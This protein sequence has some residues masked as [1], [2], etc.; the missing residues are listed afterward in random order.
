MDTLVHDRI[1]VVLFSI[2]HVGDIAGSLH[3]SSI[4]GRYK[5]FRGNSV[6][7]SIVAETAHPKAEI[8]FDRNTQ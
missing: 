3:Y 8:D 1:T 4:C 6:F 2:P 5:L 7:P